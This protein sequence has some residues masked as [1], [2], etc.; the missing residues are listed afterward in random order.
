MEVRIDR[1]QRLELEKTRRLA[2]RTSSRAWRMRAP[3][4]GGTQTPPGCCAPPCR[5]M[6]TI[7][8]IRG[9]VFVFHAV[10]RTAR[11]RG[12]DSIPEASEAQP[13]SSGGLHCGSEHP[14]HFES[15]SIT[16]IPHSTPVASPSEYQLVRHAIWIATRGASISVLNC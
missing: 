3:D 4:Y 1:G 11:E 7:R 6:V 16:W 10:P 13:F 5:R 14:G 12:A 15:A 8:R 9:L 2:I